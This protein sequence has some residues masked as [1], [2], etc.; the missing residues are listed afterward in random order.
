MQAS[1]ESSRALAILNTVRDGEQDHPDFR[2][3]QG[4]GILWK[5]SLVLLHYLERKVQLRG[6]KVLEISSG[7]GDLACE[8]QRYGAH[9]TATEHAGAD[10]KRLQE[11]VEARKPEGDSEGSVRV[12]PLTWGED[13][14]SRSP[15][16]QEEAGYDYIV[17]SELVFEADLHDELLWSMRRLCSPQT[18]IYHIFL[19]RPFSFMF[20]AKVDDTHEFEVEQVHEDELE[21]RKFLPEDSELHMHIMKLK[22]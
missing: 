16:A 14:W 22:A 12:V 8:L 11:N 19:D 2:D 9:V 10:V 6:K 5:A 4:G 3:V 15:L 7:E 21:H 18:T 1:D 17:M 13:A 20:L